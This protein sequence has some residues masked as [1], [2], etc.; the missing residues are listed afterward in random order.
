MPGLDS[1]HSFAPF[2][3]LS[4]SSFF[5]QLL[6]DVVTISIKMGIFP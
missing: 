6:N 3:I 4:S 5:M 1:T 2:C